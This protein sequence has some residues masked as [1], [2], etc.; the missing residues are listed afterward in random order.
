MKNPRREEA[1]GLNKMRK[2]SG[3]VPTFDCGNCGCK[4]YS[5]CTCIKKLS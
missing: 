3:K 4:R 5:K 1:K 2:V